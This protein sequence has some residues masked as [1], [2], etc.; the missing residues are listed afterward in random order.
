MLTREEKQRVDDIYYNFNNGGTFLG[1]TKVHQILKS[2]GFHSLGLHKIRRYIQS[3]DDY[4]LQKP[5]KRFFKRARVEVGEPFEQYDTDLLDMTSLAKHNSGVKYLL[6][7]IDVFSRFLWV[8]P[9]K[10]KTAKEVLEGFK[11]IVERGRIPKKIHSDLGKEYNNR[12]FKK[13]CLDND[14]H[15]FTAQSEFH[16]SMVERV[17][18]TFKTMIFRYFTKFRTYRYIDNLQNFVDSY[19]STPHRSLNGTAPKD[20]NDSNQAD[21]FAYM[22]LRKKTKRLKRKR[23]LKRKKPNPYKF[24]VGSL[25]RIS[26]TKQLFNRAYQQQWTSEIFKIHKIF[27]M[28]GIPLY[29]LID[30]LND[31]IKG[32]F[33]QSE[34]QRVEKDEHTLWF[35]EKKIRKR[36]RGGQIEWL[37]QF[38]GWPSKY[39]QWIPEK[40]IKD[41]TG[42]KDDTLRNH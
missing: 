5:V 4:S 16:A 38:E 11:K 20:V 33:Y 31:P 34:L 2:Q 18:R 25:V 28:Q 24:K 30:F 8:E 26:H 36:K 35:I 9:I 1:P 27:L 17:N 19:N 13:W 40:D 23:T 6:M 14:I 41:V 3:L 22:Y 42:D 32:N 12:W 21:L 10:T 29:Q 15:Y 7:V 39:N 37:V